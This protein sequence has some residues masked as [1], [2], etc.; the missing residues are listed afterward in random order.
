M[1]IK[2]TAFLGLCRISNLP[3]VFGNCVAAWILGGGEFK[4]TLVLLLIGAA[5]VYSSGMVM[6]DAVDVEFDKEF[7]P[8]RPIP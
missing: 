2:F 6:N 4:L 8:E 7:R 3:T 1:P 5:F